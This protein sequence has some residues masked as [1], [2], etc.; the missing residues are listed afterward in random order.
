MVGT[1]NQASH[2]ALMYK[3]RQILNNNNILD[4][5]DDWGMITLTSD[6]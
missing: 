6:S 3:F 1:V 2:V 5:A 4:D